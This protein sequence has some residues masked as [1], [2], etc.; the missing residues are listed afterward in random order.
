MGFIYIFFFSLYLKRVCRREPCKCEHRLRA[1]RCRTLRAQYVFDSLTVTR[2]SRWK[3]ITKIALSQLPTAAHVRA[4]LCWCLFI[5]IIYHFFPFSFLPLSIS[6]CVVQQPPHRV[7]R[8]FQ[9]GWRPPSPHE[10][11]QWFLDG[12]VTAA[13]VRSFQWP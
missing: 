6:L 10:V 1:D 12:G 3:E 4:Q 9:G 7:V 11:A 2:R 8:P 5:F 13:A